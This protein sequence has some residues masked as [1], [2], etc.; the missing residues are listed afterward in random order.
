MDPVSRVGLF[1]EVAKHQSFAKAARALGMTGPALSKQVQALEDQLGV[2]LLQRTTR[3]VT[4]TEEGALYSERARKALDDLHEAEMLVQDLRASPAGL[5]K[6]NAPMS[7][8]RRYLTQPIAAFAKAYPEVQLEVDFDDRR[9]DIIAEGYDVVIRIGALEDSSLIARQIAGCPIVLCATPEFV[10]EHGQ[11]SSVEELAALPAII[12]TR[13]GHQTDWRYRAPD[14]TV[15]SVGLRM[16]FAANNAEMML[17]A[18]L[19]G[20]GVAV[21]PIF[22]AATHLASGQLVELLPGYTTHP[23]R[24][25]Y[26]MFPQNRHLSARTR[27]FIDW[28]SE[29]SKAFPW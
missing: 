17:E 25:I 14:G 23:E 26:A 5:L 3:Q 7:F 10:T 2:R 1:L 11:P 29:C 18:C 12:Y 8:G 15:G 21:L 13:H 28:L 24:G 6:V 27:L 19:Q 20:V 9:V 16:H 4:L 22:A